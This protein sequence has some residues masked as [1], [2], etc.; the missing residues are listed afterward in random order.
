MIFIGS[1][2]EAG[3]VRRATE[4]NPWI[5]FVGPKLGLER[6]PY[7]AISQVFLMPGLV[8]LA[9]L[10]C[11]ALGVP[12]VTCRHSQHS[13]EIEYLEPGVNGIVVEKSDDPASYADA[14]VSIL[15]D[16]ELHARLVQGCQESQKKY[17]LEEMVRRFV[18]GIEGALRA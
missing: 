5:H 18:E 8:G 17:S 9:V 11:F 1:G 3:K 14:V 7:F 10:D 13:P 4:G 12:L 16:K 15:S 2:I 6:V